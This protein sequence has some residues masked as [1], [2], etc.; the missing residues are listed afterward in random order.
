MSASIKKKLKDNILLFGK[1]IFPKIF[2][3]KTPEFHKEI[4]VAIQNKKQTYVNI[5][6]PR[7]SAK[8]MLVGILK[9]LHHIM[10]DEGTKVVVLVSRTQGHAINLLQT[11]KDTLDY[12]SEFRSVF[13]YWGQHS[14]KKWSSTEI[15]LKDGSA[16]ICKG[17]GQQI[18]GMNIGGNRVTLVVLDDPEDENNTRTTEAMEN[19]LRWLLQSA[20]PTLDPHRGRLLVIGTPLHQ[21]CL[22][23]TLKDIRTWQTL[24][25]SY[26]I[27]DDK[28]NKTSLWKEMKTV[29]ELEEELSALEDIGRASS[30]YKE[31][32]CQIVGDE[33]QLFVQDYIKYYDGTVEIKDKEGYLHITELNGKK[34]SETRAINIFTG[35]DPASSTNQSADYS[36]IFNLGIDK[37]KNRFTLPYFRKRVKPLTLAEAIIKNYKKYYATKTRIESVGYQEMLRDYVRSQ[38]YIPGVEI[39]ENPRTSKSFRLESLQPM[40]ASGQIYILKSQRELVDELLMYPRGK[41]DD[42]LDGLFYSNKNIY[43]PY[44]ES[45]SIKKDEFYREES[46]VYWELA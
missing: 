33:D 36:V 8:S 32:L 5:I 12:G 14:A 9:T 18:R 22:V 27:E 16:I 28:G 25:Y 13:G 6:A 17:M 15:I 40:F 38:Q 34:V 42:L 31:R 39:K 4:A 43:P 10:F 44:H 45:K 11:I 3:L 19:N 37:D 7:G 20:I 21:R 29:E 30:F 24:H 1:I 41:H 26:W 2:H 23:Y 46:K 35:V